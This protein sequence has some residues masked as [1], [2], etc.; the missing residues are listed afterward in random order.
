MAWIYPIIASPIIILFILGLIILYRKKLSISSRRELFDYSVA[1]LS[2]SYILISIVAFIKIFYY[3][4]DLMVDYPIFGVLV[5]IVT[6]IS[7]FFTKQV[8]KLGM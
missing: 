1:F 5:V 4:G 6:T 8:Q 3:A 2:L 7:L